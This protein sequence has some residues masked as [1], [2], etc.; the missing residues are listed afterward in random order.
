MA[1]RLNVVRQILETQMLSQLDL[2]HDAKAVKSLASSKSG[3]SLHK[4]TDNTKPYETEIVHL[5]GSEQSPWV[6]AVL[7]NTA[8]TKTG[9]FI[10]S[11]TVDS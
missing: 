4:I 6:A 3:P 1:P 8:T 9:T 2:V 7:R 11:S 10:S 5:I